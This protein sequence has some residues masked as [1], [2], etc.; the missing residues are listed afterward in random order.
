MAGHRPE[1]QAAR[2]HLGIAID[3]RIGKRRPSNRRRHNTAGRDRAKPGD[4]HCRR[5]SGPRVGSDRH[6]RTARSGTNA[7]PGASD[8]TEMGDLLTGKF[9]GNGITG[10]TCIGRD[11]LI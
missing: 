4:S 5:K 2:S 11:K 9:F 1:Y 7:C 8:G 3:Y 10:K 6:S